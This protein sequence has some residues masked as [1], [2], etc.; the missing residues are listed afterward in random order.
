MMMVPK[1][2]R[3]SEA[4]GKQFEK[5][6][7]VITAAK[8]FINLFT[9]IGMRVRLFAATAAAADMAGIKAK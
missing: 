3:N 8:A 5:G 1:S 6:F 2:E 9:S 4:R 7:N